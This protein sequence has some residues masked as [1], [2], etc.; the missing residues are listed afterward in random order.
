MSASNPDFR[1][2]IFGLEGPEVRP[3]EAD[4]FHEV[5]PW[6]VILFA[7]NVESRAQL[8]ELTDRL[9]SLSGNPHLPI[10]IDQEGG[11]VARVKPPLVR[12]YPPM[13]VYATL[14][15]RDP[16]LAVDAARS[17][18]SLLARDMHL[19]GI[20]IVCAPC[21]DLNWPGAH[22]I[23]G[24]RA[25]GATVDQVAVLGQAVLDG[26]AAGG[27]L[28][29]IKHLPGHGR[30]AV[31]SHE[32]LPAVEASVPELK[33]HD[34]EVFRRLKAPLMGMTG[35]LRFTSIDA[36]EVSTFSKP[37]IE[38]VVRGHIGFDGLL[39]TDDVSMGALAGPMETRVSK[40][41]AA[42]CDLILHCNAERTEMEAIARALPDIPAAAAKPR[43]AAVDRALANLT[44]S[45][46]DAAAAAQAEVWGELLGDLFPDAQNTL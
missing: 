25:L 28:P 6:G 13:G 30:A 43:F 26:L 21:L 35:H 14:Y 12:A 46:D 18:A 27:V 36:G 44:C 19:L 17:G 10:L 32:C 23:I 37:V 45:L 16:H 33:A 38:N 1:P 20:N 11:R 39:M 15:Q 42:G 5:R 41:L 24:D 31:D 8:R 9:R 40:S 7:R 22:D 29:V 34:F 4:F 2:V 3:E